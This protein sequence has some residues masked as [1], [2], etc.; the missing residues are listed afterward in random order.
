LEITPDMDTFAC[1]YCGTQQ[2]VQR[3]GGTVS[4]K[5]IGEAIARVQVGTDRTAAE[6]TIQRLQHD[7]AAIAEQE[8][9][10]TDSGPGGCFVVAFIGF[11]FG[12]GLVADGRTW[13]LVLVIGSLVCCILCIY[14]MSVKSDRVQDLQK[15]AQVIQEKI[16]AEILQLENPGTQR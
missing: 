2:T 1:G 4:L 11:L 13:A 15:R 8:K 10:I 14:G 3:R 9:L 5:Q 7:L 12:S 6:L 16:D